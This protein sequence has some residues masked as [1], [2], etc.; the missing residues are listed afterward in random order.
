MKIDLSCPVELWHFR[1]PTREDPRVFLQLFNLSDKTLVSFQASYLCYD[2][3]QALF[4]RQIERTQSLMAESRHAF[5]VQTE[6]EEGERAARMD[7]I[8][9]KAWFQDGTVWRKNTRALSEYTDNR[10]EP[11]QQLKVLREIAG[12]DAVGYPGDQGEIWVCVCGRPNENGEECCSRCERDR[13]EQFTSFHKAAVESILVE[14]A[15]ALEEQQRLLHKAQIEEQEAAQNAKIKQKKR[16]KRALILAISLVLAAGLAYVGYF[17]AY[18]AYSYYRAERQLE[19]GEFD[20]AKSGFLSLNH[21]RDS[22]SL[23][24]EADYLK[25][26]NIKM[27]GTVTALKNAEDLFVQLKDYRDS[28]DQV[29]SSRYERAALLLKNGDYAQAIGLYEGLKDYQASPEKAKETAYLWAKQLISQ[30]DYGVAREKL[31]SLGAYQDAPNLA[32][33]CLMIPALA[34]MDQKE[35]SKAAPLFEQ[36]GGDQA[37]QMKLKECYYLWGELLFASEDYDQ[38]AQKYL[39]SGDYKDAFR[40]ASACLYEPAKKLMAS[41]EYALAKEKFERIKAYQDAATLSEECSY[42]M[43]LKAIENH[44][45]EEAITRFEEAPNLE[46]AQARLKESAYQ[47]ALTAQEGMDWE[48]AAVFFEK[49][50][51]F[52]GAGAGVLEARYRQGLKLFENGHYEEAI[53]AFKQAEPYEGAAL[54]LQ[55]AQYALAKAFFADGQ[56][57]KAAEAFLGLD[58]YEDSDELYKQ[59]V[60]AWAQTLI[61]DGKIEE[62]AKQLEK[63]PGYQNADSLF[64]ELSYQTAQ[65]LLSQN[66]ASEAM[67]QLQK[68]KGYQNADELYNGSVYQQAKTL[69]QAGEFNEA[70]KLYALIPDYQDAAKLS[71]ECYDAYYENAYKQARESLKKKEYKAALDLL[72]T[73]DRQNPGDKYAD[74]NHLYDKACYDYAN[75]LYEDNKPYEALIYYRKIPD[76]KDIDKKLDR[77]AYRIL[78]TWQ[79]A[80][81]AVFLFREDGTCQIEGKEQFFYAKNLRLVSGDHRERLNQNFQIV[82]ESKKSLTLRNIQ[83]KKLYKLKRMAD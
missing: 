61:N 27:V 17:H 36:L 21:Y 24:L 23:A 49:A 15:N 5:E 12:E 71:E 2:E 54:G 20:R 28:T 39:L 51:D 56:N 69:Q 60:Y 11:S 52:E 38:A 14:R 10:L 18:P 82:S 78:G 72:E 64:R 62:A 48:K 83:T 8:I 1:L 30:M 9:E 59:A 26:M 73:L 57:E 68:I 79:T 4:S 35:Y 43:G 66:K 45:W 25:A 55:N 13:H 53:Q 77:V 41:G 16:R 33:E 75:A 7:F 67:E 37:A 80:K 63:I 22:A 19:D 29:R 70:A 34:Y 74:I 65:K 50:G 81:G 6:I 58:G 31:L 40:K 32:K 76:Y 3:E 47:A 46:E 44:R 42:E